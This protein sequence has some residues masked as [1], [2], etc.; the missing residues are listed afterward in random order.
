MP[1]DSG[2]TVVTNARAFYTPRAAAGASGTRHSPLPSWGSATP[3]LG[4]IVQAQL[5]RNVSRGC[6][7]ISCRHCC[8]NGSAQ[9]AAPLARNDEF[10]RRPR[11]RAIQYSEAL[12]IGPKIRGVLDPPLW[13][14]MTASCEA[15]LF[16][17]RI[18]NQPRC[19]RPSSAAPGDGFPPATARWF[20]TGN[21]PPANARRGGSPP[22]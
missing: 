6:G 16:E 21:A 9:S 12:M 10:R 1:G 5:G 17:I 11:K 8:A 2:A 13:R 7:G 20:A 22:R 14:S 18:G 3:S 4:R 19:F 15:W